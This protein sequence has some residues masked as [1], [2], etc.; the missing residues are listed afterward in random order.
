[1]GCGRRR[2]RPE[3]R[4]GRPARSLRPSLASG[5]RLSRHPL[6]E[7]RR[8]RG[9][10]RGDIPGGGGR[11]P[12]H[13]HRPSERG[14][15]HRRG[16]PQAR[17][18]LAPAGPRGGQARPGLPGAARDRGS[19]GPGA[20]RRPS[21]RGARPPRRPPPGGARPALPR[22]A[23]GARGGRSPGPHGPCHRGAARP[24]PSRLPGRLRREERPKSDP[25]EALHLPL[26]PVEPRPAPRCGPACAP[27]S[28]TSSASIPRPTLEVPP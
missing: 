16:P 24:G 6:R 9:S 20:R 2:R 10:H 25:L 7:R 1:M 15:A 12:A 23:S 26:V 5:V 3:L 13:R 17:R 22:W 18:S 21:P 19:V 8:G 4:R 14:L 27:G 11:R 28:P